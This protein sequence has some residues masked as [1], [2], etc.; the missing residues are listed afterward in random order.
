MDAHHDTREPLLARLGAWGILAAV[1]VFGLS[2]TV[3]LS[4]PDTAYVWHLNMIS[5]LGDTQ[6]RA[7]GGRWICSPGYRLFNAGLV[8]TGIL[9]GLA[10]ALLIRRWGRVLGGGV[11]V[12]GVGIF[13]AG[14]FPA[15]ETAE[16]HLAGVVL[17]L[18]TPGIGL[19]LSGIRPENAW[20]TRWR[21]TR[22]ILG[23]GAL[24][25][26]AESRLPN[27]LLPQGASEWLIVVCLLLG[28]TL[29]ALRVLVASR[30]HPVS[31]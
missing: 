28:L 17:G 11:I 21:A 6:C 25:F 16:L 13:V 31:R 14:I 4:H 20:L 23:S 22:V 24:L 5:D 8:A 27:P 10:G 3:A 15:G 2:V 18:V 1:V 9:L 12:M 30:A 26:S 19:L 7:R 29:E